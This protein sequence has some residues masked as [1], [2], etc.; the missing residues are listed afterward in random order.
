MPSPSTTAVS[1][2]LRHYLRLYPGRT[3][4]VVVLL[5]IAGF[6]EGISVIA[7]LPLVEFAMESGTASGGG[8]GSRAI[9]RAIE[10]I[11]LSP[12]VGTL[13]GIIVVGFAVKAAVTLVAM[14]ET[15][16]AVAR[17][18]TDLRHRLIAAI[19]AAQ[20]N[21]FLHQPLGVFANALGAETIRAGVTYQQAA[22][23]AAIL[24]QAV[25]YG[26]ATAMV[27]WKVALFGV[28]AGVVGLFT[29]R[30]VVA[31]AQDAGGRQTDLL[32]S[33]SVR[34]TDMLQGIKAIK[35]MGAERRATP[36]LDQEILDLDDAQRKQVWSGELLRITQEPVLVVFLAVG[37]YGA[38]AFGG[39][40]LS[41]LMVVAVLFYR[42]FNRFQAAQE[43]YQ[44][45]AGG[46][47]AYWAMHRLSEDTERQCERDTGAAKA[48]S[49]VPRI[50]IENVSFAYG[51]N[52]VLRDVSLT[53]GPGEFLAISGSSGG[54]KTTLLDMLC[55]L[56][57]P[58][59]GRL[60]IDGTDLRDLR[61]HDWRGRIGYVPQ[62]MLLLHDTVYRN[63]TLADENISREDV[64]WALR[65]AGVW[66]VV[67]TLPAGMDTLVGERGGRFSGG[68]RQRISLARALVR[69]PSLLLLDEITSALDENTE[70]E[71]C[72]TLKHLA[73]SM[74]IVAV[75]HQK[76]IARVADRVLRLEGGVLISQG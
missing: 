6:A 51:E 20:W 65:A 60:R 24:I 13:L 2:L 71:V 72:A 25:V 5:S 1:S 16:Y 18:M 29:F 9:S 11:G 23:L 46:E 32:R 44:Q 28:L 54:G 66:D 33:L 62:E 8:G 55:G 48:P 53:I 57:S 70:R 76:E 26:V 59:S 42:L 47:S 56:L 49:G 40:S 27:S 36:L 69:R 67:A 19:T 50:E 15:G 3:L 63:V 4:F 45:V 39:E 37:I 64:E 43:I 35:A 21:Y 68:Q 52:A 30:R 7:L 12:S 74:T 38:V 58:D 31:A 22:R 73:G 34:T 41:A 10:F 14:K 75:S 61:L 17:V